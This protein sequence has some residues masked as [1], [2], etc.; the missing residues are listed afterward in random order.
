MNIFSVP[1]MISSLLLLFLGIFLLQKDSK[2]NQNNQ[3]ALLA[4]S[5]GLWFLAYVFM[6][7]SKN[8]DAAL[9]F[10]RIG[11]AGIIMIPVFLWG[12][13]AGYANYPILKKLYPIAM[14][15]GLVFLMLNFS[16]SFITGV[17]KYFWGFYPKGGLV[18]IAF[19]VWFCFVFLVSLLVFRKLAKE[20][21]VS[22]IRARY[23]FIAFIFAIFGCTDYLANFGFA[24][25]PVGYLFSTACISVVFYAIVRYRL[26]DIRIIIK[27]GLVYAIVTAIVSVLYII[28]ITTAELVFSRLSYLNLLWFIVPAI[29]VLS[30]VLMPL[31]DLVQDLVD[32]TL[33]RKQR[34]ANQMAMRFSEGIKEPM[35]LDELSKY[36]TRAATRVF[37]LKG[38]AC[39]V[40][41]PKT[42][43]FLCTDARGDLARFKG[44]VF[45]KNDA[46]AL[47]MAKARSTLV[48]EELRDE[49]LLVR[50]KQL[51]IS[52][53]V[54][55]ISI[56]NE[57]SLIGFLLGSDPEE[58]RLFSEEDIYLL[59][60][61]GG[62]ASVS[63]ENALLYRAQV[64]E[65]ER[66]MERSRMSELGSAAAGVAHEAKNALVSVYAVSQMLALK[67]QDAAFLETSRTMISSEVERMRILMEGVI[68]YS[69]PAPLDI[70]S[71]KLKDLVEETAVLVRDLAKGKTIA[72]EV[73][74][75]Q[76]VLVKADKNALKQVFL[77]LF[78]N[79][80]EAIGKDGRITVSSLSAVHEGA[81]NKVRIFFKDTGPGIPIAKQKK[82]LEPFFTTK[83][84]GTGLGL[85]IVKKAVEANSG[86][87]GLESAPGQ[88][89]TFIIELCEG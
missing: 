39:F 75:G 14:C 1:I 35:D 77:N 37:K 43:N 84:Q 12:F 63:I 28:V 71:E 47:A 46:L 78:L 80:I 21:T 33:F 4:F 68:N 2:A 89:A 81:H 65:I 17:Y 19:I 31:I 66:T 18:L 6:Y 29:V 58:A 15:I 26:M 87:L 11:Y 30:F 79:A 51:G 22:S 52:L 74:V 42:N 82:I 20:R 24:V 3:F 36:L 48:S 32:R 50:M 83:E 57:N 9:V 64:E 55:S 54:P 13:T 5:T 73:E 8:P 7:N 69:K 23:L 25:Y 41:D 38:A 61:F 45:L 53:C 86:T 27:K 34:R 70:K 40:A 72:I 59:D 62:Q 10:A 67:K 16:G 85:A 76:E 49:G 60:S 44:S 88:G 56:K